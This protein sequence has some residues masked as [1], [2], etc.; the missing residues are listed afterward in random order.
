MK[1]GII[2][3]IV[4]AVWGLLKAFAKLVTRF[5]QVLTGLIIFLGLYIPLF[6]VV[7]GIILLATT[8]FSFGGTGT[9]QILYYI[10][11]AL[12]CVATIIISVRNLLMRPISQIFA[13][14]IEYRDE[15]RQSREAKRRGR[16]D[17]YYDSEEEYSDGNDR[18][19]GKRG[20]DVRY[21]EDEASERPD[22]EPYYLREEGKG[23]NRREDRRDYEE[24]AGRRPYPY[25][26]EREDR[27]YDDRDYPAYGRRSAR[28]AERPLVYYSK[29]RPGVLVKEYSDRFELFE[30]AAGGER[31][32]GTEY[33]DE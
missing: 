15:M 5:I 9:N 30:D 14:L 12:C 19:Y 24:S 29:R 17:A 31:Y 16:G 25:R 13:P 22:D 10:G 6:Y 8:D 1:N 18:R 21:Y 33:K 7:F 32:L 26:T 23:R 4:L 27:R 2:F 11:L 28:E 3:T 20:R